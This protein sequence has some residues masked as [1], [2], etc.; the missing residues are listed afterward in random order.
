MHLLPNPSSKPPPICTPCLPPLALLVAWHLPWAWLRVLQPPVTPLAKLIALSHPHLPYEPCI[1]R[2]VD[3]HNLEDEER[4]R[5]GN[6]SSV[7]DHVVFIL[8]TSSGVEGKSQNQFIPA[9]SIWELMRSWFVVP[10]YGLSPCFESG[11]W[12]FPEIIWDL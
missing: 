7:A 5:E 9:S 6:C 1:E 11:H 2:V 10:K 12:G 8:S 4:R 3:R